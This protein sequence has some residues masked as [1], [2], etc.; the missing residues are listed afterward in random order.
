MDVIVAVAAELRP[1]SAAA[2]SRMIHRIRPAKVSPLRP[3]D[4]A[5][6]VLSPHCNP[7]S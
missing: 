2:A 7:A 4:S 1:I 6:A 5:A 3:P